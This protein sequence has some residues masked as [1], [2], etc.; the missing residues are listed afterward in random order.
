MIVAVLDAC[1]LYPPSL[2][3]LLMWLATTGAY[4]P[5]W[6]ETIQSEWVRNV[7]EDNPEITRVQL[8]RTGRLMIETVPDGLVEGYEMK[9]SE[10]TLPDPGDLHVLAAAIHTSASH[11]VTV[12]LTDFPKAKLEPFGLEAIHPDLFLTALLGDEESLF[13]RGVNANRLSLSKP[14]KNARQY[15]DTLVANGLHETANQ[16]EKKI[17]LI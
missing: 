4:S 1:V 7:L 15:I 2:R 10:L 9:I 11:I 17:H 14:A 6:S 16:L 5:R 12:N 13:L 8:D 3:D